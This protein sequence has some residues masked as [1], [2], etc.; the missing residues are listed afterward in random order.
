[1]NTEVVDRE[2]K[3]KLDK[4]SLCDEMWKRIEYT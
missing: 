3:R 4:R 1:M 2:L